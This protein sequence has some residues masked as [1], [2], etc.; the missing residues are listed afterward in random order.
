M[1][2]NDVRVQEIATIERTGDCDEA[3][4]LRTEVDGQAV[5][6]AEIAIDII[7]WTRPP[8]LKISA[9]A[10]RLQERNRCNEHAACTAR[11]SVSGRIIEGE[12]PS[13]W[14]Q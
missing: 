11:H 14:K 6:P 4:H 9:V 13:I 12:M 8:F 1:Q 7:E 5:A 3:L 2:G 10:A